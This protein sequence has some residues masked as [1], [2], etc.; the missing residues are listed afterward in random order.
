MGTA[1]KSGAGGGAGGEGRLW[2]PGVRQRWHTAEE[3]GYECGLVHPEPGPRKALSWSALLLRPGS[4]SHV[5][6]E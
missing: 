5:F 4:A 2:L 6:Y 1:T 3:G